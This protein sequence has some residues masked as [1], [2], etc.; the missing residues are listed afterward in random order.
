LQLTNCTVADNNVTGEGGGL[1]IDPN[2]QYLASVLIQNS[3]FWGNRLRGE[4]LAGSQLG[5]AGPTRVRFSDVE[6]GEPYTTT[7]NSKL[8]WELSNRNEDP[9]F[10]D[11]AQ[12]DYRLKTG[13]VASPCIDKGDN[14]VVES[15]S[16]AEGNA[17]IRNCKVDLGAIESQPTPLQPPSPEAPTIVKSR[18]ISFVP[19]NAGVQ[20]AIRVK[21]VSMHH[22][23]PPYTGGPSIPFTPFEGQVRWV[24]PPTQYV[25]SASSGIP[26]YASFLQCAPEYRDWSTVGLLHVT[27]DAVVPSSQYEVQTLP[28]ESAACGDLL[29]RML[30][31]PLVLTT[32]R[33]GDI[34]NPFNPPSPD[35]QPDTSDISALVDKFKSSLGAPIKA[36]ALLAD[37]N[38]EIASDFNFTHISMCV[39]AFKGLPYPYKP[40]K[41]GG[42]AAKSCVTAADCASQSVAGPCWSCPCID[43]AN[44]SADING[45]GYIDATDEALEETT[46]LYFVVNSDDD[47]GN[48]IEDYL[49][50]GPAFFEDDLVELRLSAK[51]PPLD[52]GNAWWEIR[53]DEPDP[54]NPA[55]K[56]WT[57]YDKSNGQGGPGTPI[58]NGEPNFSWPPPRS[59]WLEALHSS[60]ET[61]LTLTITDNTVSPTAA[62]QGTKTST[63]TVTA[64]C[65]PAPS[66]GYR[67][68]IG[69]VESANNITGVSANI[70]SSWWLLD[71]L[72]GSP[73]STSEAL[74]CIWVDIGANNGDTEIWVQMGTGRERR[75]GSP[76][77][78]IDCYV[79]ARYGPGDNDI[80]TFKPPMSLSGEH[81]Y[82]IIQIIPAL[83]YWQFYL[84]SLPFDDFRHDT[85][86]NRGGE[87]AEWNA[88]IENLEDH[89]CGT[90]S[91]PCIFSDCR[92]A[93]NWGSGIQTDL[94]PSD[95]SL[96]PD[97]PFWE[98][99][100]GYEW[101]SGTSFMVWD[102]RPYSRVGK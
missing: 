67:Y 6:G 59:V 42:D 73:M 61:Q 16:D 49:D 98:I 100:W 86:I 66:P 15:N 31:E 48:G 23:V 53:W 36:R 32:G 9:L 2:S 8:L 58:A 46:P 65:T 71:P 14:G 13:P 25:E 17:R 4:L 95:I 21:L 92:Y 27:G 7:A 75:E 63:L 102:N 24:G 77:E 54:N 93:V 52:L 26:F 37:N 5:V 22:V 80:H 29:E 47:N 81:E 90:S 39:D 43:E 44:I 51:C 18:F 84:D 50:D 12:G 74:S 45:D 69:A 41:C 38:V 76:Y 91:Q 62:A 85:W 30:S 70:T 55:L 1:W 68:W 3:I 94:A 33:W 20:T 72:C 57:S 60:G 28:S 88:E 82:T 97:F 99:E 78:T 40:G 64:P 79:E 89:L 101:L 10:E 56:V 83:G 96:H 19:G 34:A 35:P 11:A 87:R